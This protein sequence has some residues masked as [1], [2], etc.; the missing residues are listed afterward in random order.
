[1]LAARDDLGNPNCLPEFKI[2]QGRKMPFRVRVLTG[3]RLMHLD[4]ICDV[5]TA[6]RP[7]DSSPRRESLVWQL[8]RPCLCLSSSAG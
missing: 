7:G 3:I 1:M 4:S 5:G 6:W 2:Y 8:C